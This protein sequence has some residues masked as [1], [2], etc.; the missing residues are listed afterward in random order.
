MF[1]RYIELLFKLESVERNY[2][3]DSL[4]AD[5]LRTRM[6]HFEALT[7]RQ[8]EIVRMIREELYGEQEAHSRPLATC[9][10]GR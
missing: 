8:A 10:D 1:R 4:E 2:G 5:N 7:P 9:P 6:S 3:G